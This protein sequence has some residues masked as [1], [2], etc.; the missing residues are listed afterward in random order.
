[1]SEALATLIRSMRGT[2]G[3]DSS[4]PNELRS[5]LIA[6]TEKWMRKA[7]AAGEVVGTNKILREL[8]AAHIDYSKL[9]SEELDEL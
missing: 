6:K 9:G 7:Y 5:A 4:I 3:C 8:S 1:M 2:L